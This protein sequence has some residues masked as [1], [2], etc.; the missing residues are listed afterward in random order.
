MDWCEDFSEMFG[1][2]L[3][4]LGIASDSVAAAELVVSLSAN[5]SLC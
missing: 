5:G 2:N 1:E 3:C 4:S